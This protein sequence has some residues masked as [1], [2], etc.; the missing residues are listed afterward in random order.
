MGT[1]AFSLMPSCC[2]TGSVRAPT[3]FT[4]SRF[5]PI[6]V[7]A[8]GAEVDRQFVFE[9]RTTTWKML[10]RSWR[11]PM[12]RVM[13]DI[14]ASRCSLLAEPRLVRPAAR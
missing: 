2:A 9:L 13:R 14:S 3:Q 8:D 10:R 5:S 1:M 7:Q 11:S 6:V 4:V 12:A